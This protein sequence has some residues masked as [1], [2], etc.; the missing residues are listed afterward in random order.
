MRKNYRFEMFENP[1][2][3]KNFPAIL[4]YIDLEI[5]ENAKC[6]APDIDPVIFYEGPF[7][8]VRA[9]ETDLNSRKKEALNMCRECP[10]R[11][12]CL[13]SSIVHGDIGVIIGGKTTAQRL[14]MYVPPKASRTTSITEAQKR[15]ARKSLVELYIK[16]LITQSEILVK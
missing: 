12:A 7:E 13:Q 5:H 2:D 15:V 1:Q 3:P 4:S 10:V 8:D 16:D 6:A 9:N 14:R 11:D